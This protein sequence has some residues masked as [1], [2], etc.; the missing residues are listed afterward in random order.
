MCSPEV[1]T[2]SSSILCGIERT[3][4]LG[5][6]HW[7]CMET[8]L[9]WLEH[10]GTNCHTNAVFLIASCLEVCIGSYIYIWVSVCVCVCV[11]ATS[12]PPRSWKKLGTWR[13]L[14]S[15]DEP[16]CIEVATQVVN[17]PSLSDVLHPEGDFV[18]L[19]ALIQNIHDE[20]GSHRAWNRNMFQVVL[21]GSCLQ[22]C[23]SSV[24]VCNV[25]SHI[26]HRASLCHLSM[27]S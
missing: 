12:R 25:L 22:L 4:G 9:L 10:R 15:M 21:W 13:S 2:I 17:L 27:L 5:V 24:E 16:A 11:R 1:V 26:R 14:F 19:P 8:K 20:R 23:L 18:F 6:C 7:P 3:L